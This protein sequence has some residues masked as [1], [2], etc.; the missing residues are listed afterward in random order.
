MRPNRVGVCL[1]GKHRSA[2]VVA[3]AAIVAFVLA[4]GLVVPSGFADEAEPEQDHPRVFAAKASHEG[5]VVYAET[6]DDGVLEHV[7]DI[8]Q[9][10]RAEGYE[11]RAA[12][13]YKADGNFIEIMSEGGI[14]ARFDSPSAVDVRTKVALGAMGI[15]IDRF[16]A[17][18][19]Q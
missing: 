3:A 14:V 7:T 11:M 12:V 18:Y 16:G 2:L 8:V 17:P 6:M 4:Q 5:V 19:E 1:R 15:Y 10:L 9:D 13:R